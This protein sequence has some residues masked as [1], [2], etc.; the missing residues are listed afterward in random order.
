MG[1]QG[2]QDPGVCLDS[3]REAL[4]HSSPSTPA[5][6]WTPKRMGVAGVEGLLLPK[7]FPWTSPVLKV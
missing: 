1:Y 5:G 4:G 6:G 7:D 3:T 2:G